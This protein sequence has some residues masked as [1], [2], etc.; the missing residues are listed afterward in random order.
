MSQDSKQSTDTAHNSSAPLLAPEGTSE[1]SSQAD[2][3][4][5]KRR[6]IELAVG[7]VALAVFCICRSLLFSLSMI[8][9]RRVFLRRIL[10]RR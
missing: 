5:R 9:R 3:K 4:K 2:S 7:A 1:A 6:R 8:R 10:L